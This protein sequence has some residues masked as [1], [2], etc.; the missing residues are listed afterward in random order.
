MPSSSPA[1]PLRSDNFDVDIPQP[2]R[3]PSETDTASASLVTVLN[4]S[5]DDD[6]DELSDETVA[7]LLREAEERM[8]NTDSSSALL[9]ITSNKSIASI[10]LP[11]LDPGASL[12][13]PP[14]KT[15]GR[16]ARIADRLL[17]ESERAL[18]NSAQPV[19]AA[20]TNKKSKKEPPPTAGSK[21]YDLPRT[22]MTD[23]FKRDFLLI[24]HRNVLD[25]HRH[26]RKDNSGIPQYSQV[27]TIIEGNT[28]FFN[29]RINRRERKKTILEEVLADGSSKERFKRKYEEVQKS[30]R[31][32]KKEF[33]KKLKAQRNKIAAKFGANKY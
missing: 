29:A 27:G 25:P 4:R 14:I 18:A 33:Y 28:E 5:D 6:D 16:V 30:K 32:G 26:Y 19:V 17:P 11:K 10:K 22:E 31:S 20:T 8:R 24:K 23:E 7:R 21:W 13:K 9:E 15:E 1:S 3:H 12:P 2:P